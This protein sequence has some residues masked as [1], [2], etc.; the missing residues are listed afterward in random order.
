MSSP[1]S[2]SSG[3]RV[4]LLCSN[5]LAIV[6]DGDEDDDDDD[7]DDG[8]DDDAELMLTQMMM[9]LLM[10][11]M[12]VIAIFRFSVIIP[13]GFYLALLYPNQVHHQSRAAAR[14]SWSQNPASTSSRHLSLH[15]WPAPQV[16]PGLG[17][18]PQ[19]QAHLAELQHPA[20]GPST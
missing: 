4:R 2:P 18:A 9:L 6:N 13:M 14:S 20:L 11:L 5:T 12:M 16:T 7:V 8:V 10:V 1:S 19:Q 15:P 3:F 17:P